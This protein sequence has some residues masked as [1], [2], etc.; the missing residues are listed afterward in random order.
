MCTHIY[1]QAPIFLS[2]VALGYLL[3]FTK[4]ISHLPNENKIH[5]L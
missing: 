5:T 2:G 1:I 3:D 4:D